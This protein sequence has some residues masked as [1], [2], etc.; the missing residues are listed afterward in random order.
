MTGIPM[1]LSEITLVLFTT[2][3]PSGAVAVALVALSTLGAG[4]DGTAL[5]ARARLMWVPLLVAMV[6]LVASATHL[7]NPSN[8]LYVLAR[9]GHSPLSN[10]VAAAVTFL[11]LTD[12]YWLYSFAERPRLA[13][14][15]AWGVALALLAAA[16][17]T[18]VSM[19]Y[20]A[21][22]IPTWNG[23]LVPACL[24]ATALTGGPV[25]ALA[26]L[27]VA[28]EG[29]LGRWL[30]RGLL[31]LATLALAAGVVLEALQGGQLAALHTA[32]T[33]GAELAPHY[34]AMLLAATALRLGGVILAW[35]DELRP[36]D[37]RAA[38]TLSDS[39]ACLLVFAGIF[40]M[41]F[42]FYMAHMTV[43]L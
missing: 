14:Q 15:R 22:T 41:R 43:G 5:R 24:W 18:G 40:V 13:L 8:A 2:L 23:P 6:G 32:L 19:A 10:E 20:R 25:L 27:R 26:V 29:R 21:P 11:G 33:S 30:G 12:L 16:F 36:V 28:G 1:A 9:V 38:R 34:G 39:A 42:A 7:G 4:V 35:R 37:G 31:T 3:A 17:V